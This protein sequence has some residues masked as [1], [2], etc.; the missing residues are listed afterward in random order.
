VGYYSFQVR[1]ST[2]GKI[3]RRGERIEEKS[4]LRAVTS[5]NSGRYACVYYS[6]SGRVATLSYIIFFY[7][8]VRVRYVPGERKILLDEKKGMNELLLLAPLYL[9]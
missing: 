6:A 9:K 4:R 2:R 8:R 5:D 3:Y 1:Y 7:V